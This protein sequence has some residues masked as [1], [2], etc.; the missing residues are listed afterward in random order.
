M[1]EGPDRTETF[2]YKLYL[3]ASF[4]PDYELILQLHQCELLQEELSQ[5]LWCSCVLCLQCE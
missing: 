2:I 4:Y 3:K 1:A 5:A